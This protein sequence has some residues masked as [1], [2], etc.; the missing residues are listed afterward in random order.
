M[1][2]LRAQ[3]TGDTNKNLATIRRHL[4]NRKLGTVIHANLY[5]DGSVRVS[6][7]SNKKQLD[8]GKF[9]EAVQAI[10]VDTKLAVV[11]VQYRSEK[12]RWFTGHPPTCKRTA[13]LEFGQEAI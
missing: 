7:F 6:A 1:S 9:K 10:V 11:D 3:Y 13:I 8:L 4:T 5:S 12:Y 2:R